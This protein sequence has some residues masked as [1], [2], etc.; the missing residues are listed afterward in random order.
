MVLYLG[1]ATFREPTL[2]PDSDEV[3][4]STKSETEAKSTAGLRSEGQSPK[5]GYCFIVTTVIVLYS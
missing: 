4:R 2:L 5:E 1:N 3:G